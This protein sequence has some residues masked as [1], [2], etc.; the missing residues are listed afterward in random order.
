MS[1]FRF[2]TFCLATCLLLSVSLCCL[3][4]LAAPSQAERP[5]KDYIVIQ[6]QGYPGPL[7][8]ALR[9]RLSAFEGQPFTTELRAEILRAAREI[10]PG[11]RIPVVSQR[12]VGDGALEARFVVAPFGAIEAAPAS[13]QVNLRPQGDSYVDFDLEGLPE[14][15][16]TNMKMR[17]E[18]FRGQAFTTD[19]FEQIRRVILET[20]PDCGIVG[21]RRVRGTDQATTTLTVGSAAI[22]ARRGAAIRNGAAVQVNAAEQAGKLVKQPKPQYPPM[23][24]QARIQGVVRF[25]AVID[26]EGRVSDLKLVS[27]HPLLIP[28]AQEAAKKYRYQPTLI[29]GSPVEVTTTIDVPFTLR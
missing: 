1:R 28:S 7:A 3:D 21:M 23:A 5:S 29:D 13:S 8:E 24:Q 22:E 11:A 20:D 19:L 9:T 26:K 15:L 6:I 25:V 4:V 27:G 14:P 18:P 2:F 12:E 16:R 17:L 10:D